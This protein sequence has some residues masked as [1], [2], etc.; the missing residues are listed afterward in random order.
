MNRR[1]RAG[2]HPAHTLTAVL[3]AVA[4]CAAPMSAV[5]QTPS[6]ATLLENHIRACGGPALAAVTS[7]RRVGTLVRGQSGPVPFESVARAPGRWSYNQ[8]FAYGDQV[9]YGCDG[10]SAWVQ[11]TREVAQI[12]GRER[13][14][15]DLLLDV[16]A[17]L[18]LREVFTELAV[19]GIETKEGKEVTVVRASSREGGDVELVFERESGLLVQAGD[20]V[21]EDYRPVGEVL[22]PHRIWIGGDPDSLGLRLRMDITAITQNVTIP[23]ALFERPVAP[24]PMRPGPLFKRYRRVAADRGAM[25]ACVGSYQHPTR[26]EITYTVTRQDD[27]LMLEQTGWGQA[28]EIIPSSPWDYFI[29]FINLEA[30]FRRDDEGR[31]TALEL[32]AQRQLRA[33]RIR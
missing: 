14:D 10:D 11:D 24:L 31:V 30:H 15:L 6:A 1:S 18:R 9:T 12:S 3:W 2:S 17:P 7:E 27:H 8:V 26:P 33:E 22:R 19:K 16:Q 13:L 21:F 32:V 28:I 29:Q 4:V 20:L 23:E 25:D 5:G